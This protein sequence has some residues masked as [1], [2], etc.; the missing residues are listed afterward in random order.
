MRIFQNGAFIQ[1]QNFLLNLQCNVPV[2][3]I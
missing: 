2:T 1:L 3:I